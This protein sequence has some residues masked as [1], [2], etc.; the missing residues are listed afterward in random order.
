MEN[1]NITEPFIQKCYVDDF[2]IDIYIQDFKYP[3]VI[4]YFV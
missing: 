4:L 1:N 3:Y 2:N